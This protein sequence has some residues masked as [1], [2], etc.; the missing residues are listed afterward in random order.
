MKTLVV[1]DSQFGNTEQIARAIA[2]GAGGTTVVRAAK[3]DLID[4]RTYDMLVVGSPTQA[5]RPTADIKRFL[6]SIPAGGLAKMQVA[7][8]D[9][10]VSA[11]RCGPFA[12]LVMGIFGYAAGRMA[13]P[14]QAKG[15][16]LK[17]PPEGFAVVDKEGP[18]EPGEHERAYRWGKD[19]VGTPEAVQA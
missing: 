17:A 10:R 8:F 7:A 14:L 5:G 11:K 15:G 13:A 9:T 2:D 6:D 4:L 3:A 18:L 1:Y 19:L 12:K 16:R